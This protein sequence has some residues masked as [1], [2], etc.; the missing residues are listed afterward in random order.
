MRSYKVPSSQA[1]GYSYIIRH[2]GFKDGSQGERFKGVTTLW[3]LFQ[4][5]MTIFLKREFL[6]ARALDPVSGKMG[7]YQWITTTEASDI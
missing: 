4:R 6:G 1:P 7:D 2:P 5:K 3:D